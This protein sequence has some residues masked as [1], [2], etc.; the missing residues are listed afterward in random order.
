M[1]KF[2]RQQNQEQ[3][4]GF[5]PALQQQQQSA[6]TD[7]AAKEQVS[8]T[9]IGGTLT[10]ISTGVAALD[11][12]IIAFQNS[13]GTLSAADQAALDSIV[14]ASAALNTQAQAINVTAPAPPTQPPP[15]PSPSP[16]P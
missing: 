3:R 4:A 1:K 13:P 2:Q 16:A 15:T 7:W 10:A 8:L 12:M 6:I 9:S 5:R 11:A 14:A